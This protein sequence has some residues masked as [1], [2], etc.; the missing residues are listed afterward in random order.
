M[1]VIEHNKSKAQKITPDLCNN[2]KLC[3]KPGILTQEKRSHLYDCVISFNYSSY[4]M[5]PFMNLLSHP[6]S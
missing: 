6:P 4:C 5:L 3:L 1:A 2:R